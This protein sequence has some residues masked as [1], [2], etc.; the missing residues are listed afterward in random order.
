MF[1]SDSSKEEYMLPYPD[2]RGVFFADEGN[3][4]QEPPNLVTNPDSILPTIEEGYES[5]GESTTLY[6]SEDDAEGSPF[7]LRM[8]SVWMASLE[9]HMEAAD[10]NPADNPANQD[11]A[12]NN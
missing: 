5:E 12:I 3:S 7:H 11:N 4:E 9:E 8:E 1:G 10:A 2:L 6:N